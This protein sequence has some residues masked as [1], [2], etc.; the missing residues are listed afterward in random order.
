MAILESDALRKVLFPQPTYGWQE[1]R[2]L[3]QACYYLIE[4]LLKQCISVLFDATN[5]TERHRQALYDISRRRGVKLIL[6][7]IKASP[8]IVKQRLEKR[9]LHPVEKSDADWSVYQ[10]M[11]SREEPIHGK[12]FAV[13]TARDIQPQVDKII[14]EAIKE[15]ESRWKLTL[16]PE[17]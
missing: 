16:S 15:K 8:G 3:F 2:R 4:E 5:L 6:V 14:Q 9:K 11:R 7:R 17:I 10:L 12:H 13:D 1:S